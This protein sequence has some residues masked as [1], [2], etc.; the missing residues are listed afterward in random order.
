M[1][2]LKDTT[3][4]RRFKATPSMPDP[5]L[6]KIDAQIVFDETLSK[7]GIRAAPPLQFEAGR[8]A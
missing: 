7:L 1:S 2:E 8:V 3:I 6:D 4:F 5:H